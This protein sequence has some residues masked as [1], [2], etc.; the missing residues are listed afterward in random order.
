MLP[1]AE[2]E[3]IHRQDRQIEN[4]IQINGLLKSCELKAP[5]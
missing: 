3:A 2:R 4:A 1:G 5:T